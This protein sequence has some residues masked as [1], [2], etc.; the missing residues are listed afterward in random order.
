[1]FKLLEQLSSGLLNVPLIQK[2][3]VIG[4]DEKVDIP[5]GPPEILNMYLKMCPV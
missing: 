3:V 2:Q 5:C 4:L 1:M